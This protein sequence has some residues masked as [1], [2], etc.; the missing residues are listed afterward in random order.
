MAWVEPDPYLSVREA[1]AAAR[2]SSRRM[3]GLLAEGVVA[4]RRDGQE[5]W[6]VGRASLAQWHAGRWLAPAACMTPRASSL[7]SGPQRTVSVML[8]PVA[9]V[10]SSTTELASIFGAHAS[11]V[12]G[13]LQA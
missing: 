7:S 3:R 9:A 8:L 5:A 12:G 13:V 4:G 11:N 1:S 2:V 6:T 10:N